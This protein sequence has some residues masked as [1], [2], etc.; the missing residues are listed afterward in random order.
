MRILIYE[1]LKLG[2]KK[3]FFVFSLVLVAANLLTLYAYERYTGRFFYVHEQRENYK[4]YLN[5]DE[6]ADI[7][8]FYSL[9]QEEQEAYISSYA[10]FIDGMEERVERM[11]ST[12]LYQDKDSYV[13]RNLIKSCED[14]APFSGMTLKA[15]NDFGLRALTQ[16]NGSVLFLLVYL[17]ILTYYVLFFERD[18]NLLL[19]FKG[20]R[21]GHTPLVAA[22]LSVMVLAAFCY[23]VLMEGSVILLLGW[24]Y[25]YGDIERAVQS[26]SLFRSCTYTLTVGQMLLFTVLIRVVVAVVFACV[27]FCVGMFFKNEFTAAVLAGVVLGLE[28]LFS[29]VFSISGSFGGIK[30]VN[31]FYCWDIE[32]LLGEY[33]N[34]N[35]F[36]YPVGKNMCA[37][38]AA[39]LLV[40]LLCNLGIFAFNRT[41]Q[42]RTEGMLEVFGQ[43][44]R[45]RMGFLGRHTRL[46]YYE[47][48]KMLIQQKKGVVFVL[49]LIWGIYEI[50]GVSKTD[51]YATAREASYH[52]YIGRLKGPITEE[53]FAFMDEEEA[54]LKAKWEELMQLENASDEGYADQRRTVLMAELERYEDGF[55]MVQ[56]QLNQLK[57]KAGDIREKYLL[58]E[59]AYDDLWR[60][61]GTDIFLWFAGAAAIMYFVSG[62][63]A[64]DE[65]KKMLPLI[66]S[67]R[68][69][70]ERLNRSRSCCAAV[71]TG[72]LFLIMELP[73][74]L[75]YGKID[76]FVTA[77]QKLCDFTGAV[78]SSGLPLGLMV[79]C[80]FLLKA[81]GFFAVCFAALKL[82]KVMKSEL[83]AMLAGIGA[84]GIIAMVLYH[85]GWDINMLLIKLLQQSY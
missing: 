40:L 53:T 22:K 5:G 11:Q 13:Y 16:Y 60:D 34:L 44:L 85:F 19:L 80:V 42:I 7:E 59:M 49:L 51:Y 28:Y 1:F 12:S 64:V 29:R 54:S 36:G 67:T 27:M 32:Q 8:E 37:A 6:T 47:F 2:K 66:R 71:C 68:N 76:H 46:L 20:S 33:Y 82:S 14:F 25:G 30:C 23:T 65:K 35:L 18:M 58:D 79:A 31:P 63:Y 61:T 70:R 26:V 9:A 55:Y 39:V 78:F 56:D 17:A 83:P 73:L 69:G 84:A 38:F 81:L 62:I 75:R 45:G 57:E 4:A 10:S 43:W 3:L 77:R 50:A 15:D 21:R 74:F 41:C 52:Y 72:V 48:Y 24:M